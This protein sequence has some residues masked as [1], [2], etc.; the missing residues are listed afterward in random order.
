VHRQSPEQ[1]GSGG[2]TPT[3]VLLALLSVHPAA[4]DPG[5]D[6]QAA[7]DQAMASYRT[8]DFAA[9]ADHFMRSYALKPTGETALGVGR[10]Q[11]GLGQI[12]AALS[13]YG[14]AVEEAQWDATRDA[15]KPSIERLKASSYLVV[16]CP[17]GGAS[18]KAN[19]APLGRCP[20][21]ARYVAPGP[22][23]LQ[24]VFANGK[25]RAESVTAVA[26]RRI[27]HTLGTQPSLESGAPDLANTRYRNARKLYRAGRFD[28]AAAEL[29]AAAAI[30]PQS[31][32]L[33]YNR[34]RVAEKRQRWGEALEAY[35]LYLKL[36]KTEADRE[37]VRRLVK[38]LER[39]VESDYAT[40]VVSSEPIQAKVFLDDETT[41]RGLTP[42]KLR[43]PA[44]AHVLRVQRPHH[45]NEL[46]AVD[47]KPRETRALALALRPVAVEATPAPPPRKT[48][49]SPHQV[50]GFAALGVGVVGLAVGSFYLAKRVGDGTDFN[51]LTAAGQDQAR[52]STQ[53]TLES[54]LITAVVAMSLG[55]V[56]AVAGTTLLLWPEDEAPIA[57]AQVFV[58][59]GHARLILRF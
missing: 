56:A 45:H 59:P 53:E 26:G 13:W 22:V 6:A 4:A 36:G 2:R 14:K 41:A 31:V 27:E 34:G 3:L 24:L 40:I 20:T 5:G 1:L 52:E 23:R 35:R 28:E 44:G 29:R 57:G 17:A 48:G 39:R 51:G 42:L 55:G 19:G 8:Q 46:K 37:E 12:E 16:R 7:H 21:A 38:D 10:A 11:E 30:F 50:Y 32:K 54:D 47:L 49:D 33:A 18:V 43:V 15:A 58:G 25:T 9:A